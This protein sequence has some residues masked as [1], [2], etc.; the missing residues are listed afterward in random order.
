MFSF[1]HGCGSVRTATSDPISDSLIRFQRRCDEERDS[2][3]TLPCHPHNAWQLVTLIK[4]FFFFFDSSSTSAS[5]FFFLGSFT[6]FLLCC[7][8]E[9]TG[10][11]IPA[12]GGKLHWTDLHYYDFIHF[13]QIEK[14]ATIECRI[15]TSFITLIYSCRIT[16]LDV[17]KMYKNI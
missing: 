9:E 3:A 12:E 4:N 8:P 14:R 1:H 2:A 7:L 11:N 6:L 10:R 16:K 5:T 13:N 15:L 17:N